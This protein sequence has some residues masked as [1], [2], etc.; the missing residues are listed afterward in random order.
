[1]ERTSLVRLGHFVHI[2]RHSAPA[3]AERLS[4]VNP[5]QRNRKEAA[6]ATGGDII[7]V[8]PRCECVSPSLWPDTCASLGLA[9]AVQNE[10]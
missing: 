5:R 9:H 7:D 8:P 3:R 1:M 10:R 6:Q 4:A 2:S